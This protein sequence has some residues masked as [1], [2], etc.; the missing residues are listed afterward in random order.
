MSG[1]RA[2]V[3]GRYLT[4]PLCGCDRFLSKKFLVAGT[5]LQVFDLE[6]FGSSGV[7]LIC[8]RCTRIQHFAKEDAVAF[9][10]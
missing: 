6:G 9:A 5:W 7:M 8:E 1:Q 2:S 10:G 3:A 4:C